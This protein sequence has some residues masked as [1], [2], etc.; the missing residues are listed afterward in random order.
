MSLLPK[1]VKKYSN[2]QKEINKSAELFSKE[3]RS[4]KF[5]SKK[6]SY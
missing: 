2:L 6:Y 4:A 3:V 1:F 5:P